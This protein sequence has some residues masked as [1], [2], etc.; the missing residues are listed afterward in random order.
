MSELN[1]NAKAWASYMP[2]PEASELA[3][4]QSWEEMPSDSDAISG[5]K[6]VVLLLSDKLI[7]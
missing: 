6:L 3:Y 7:H 2:D 5:G 4:T 1:P